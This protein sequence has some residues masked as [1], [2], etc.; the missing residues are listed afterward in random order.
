MTPRRLWHSS[1]MAPT[2]SFGRQD[3]GGHHGFAD[4]GDLARGVFAGVGHGGHLLVLE[5]DL[6][7]HVGRR[8]DQ[9][10]VVFAFEA[11]TGDFQVE[12][13]EEAHAE[14]EAQCCGGFRLVDQRGVVEH[15]LVQRIAEHRVVGAVQRVQ[16]GEDHGLGI[17]VAA[18]RIRRRL[19]EVGDGI[20]HLGLA[21]VFTPVMR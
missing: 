10:Q 6:V 19:G 8:G 3:G 2:N 5:R 17:G 13:A 11:L 1:M 12:Q 14:A 4:L 21:D 15:Q 20:A 18:Q 16:A 9:V 7:L